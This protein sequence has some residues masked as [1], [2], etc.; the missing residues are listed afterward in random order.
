MIA[1]QKSMNNNLTNVK[2]RY[3]SIQYIFWK[4]KKIKKLYYFCDRFEI[5]YF[6]NF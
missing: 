5:D 4:N 6:I 1:P 2:Q 3:N